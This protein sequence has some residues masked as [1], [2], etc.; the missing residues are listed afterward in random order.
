M[1]DTVTTI[2]PGAAVTVIAA[3]A[4]LVPSETEVAVSVTKAG[5][6]TLA[7]AV[8]EMGAPEALELAESVPQAAPLQPAPDN[9]QA[10]PLF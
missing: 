1:G 6:G 10:T 3:A 5:D 4:D 8:Y 7:G 2:A 9:D